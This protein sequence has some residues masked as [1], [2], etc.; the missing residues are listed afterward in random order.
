MAVI[1]IDG[2]AIFRSASLFLILLG[3]AVFARFMKVAVQHDVHIDGIP[4]AILIAAVILGPAE[5][6]VI[7]ILMVLIGEL[8]YPLV[9]YIENIQKKAPNNEAPSMGHRL[10]LW[11][12]EPMVQSDT[13]NEIERDVSKA[14]WS[15]V[16]RPVKLKI[17]EDVAQVSCYALIAGLFFRYVVD[18]FGINYLDPSFY[19]VF[20]AAFVLMLAVN[21]GYYEIVVDTWIERYPFGSGFK[22]IAFLIPAEIVTVSL[23]MGVLYG[24]Y[25]FGSRTSAMLLMA[26]G[27]SA[28]LF[29]YWRAQNSKVK[30]EREA[31][32]RLT[33]RVQALH[34]RDNR[35]GTHCAAIALYVYE[36]ACAAGLSTK[37]RFRGYRA[38]LVHDVGK[39]SWPGPLLD[40]T[41]GRDEITEVDRLYIKDHP[42]AGADR[43]LGAGF[44]HVAQIIRCH[45]EN[46]DGTGYPRGFQG[47][48]IPELAKI[49]RVADTYDVI[50]ARDTYQSRRSREEAI[51]ELR[52]K[53]ELFEQ[54]YV[55]ALVEA[56]EKD[57]E[58]NYRHEDRR[59]YEEA[60]DFYTA[61][62]PRKK[63]PPKDGQRVKFPHGAAEPTGRESVV[64][65]SSD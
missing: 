2:A 52:S 13:G 16:E 33:S 65:G 7:G 11:L 26:A 54:I 25:A 50:T 44:K 46:L 60:I 3:L 53:P 34:A 8:Y 63:R 32:N 36:I 62:L 6:A 61:G 14:G 42:N 47:H 39:T 17:L 23:G 9:S 29:Y 24:Y 20:L 28:V 55:E 41:K 56:L 38:G 4:L 21:F 18:A 51:A 48:E 59:T 37:Q 19:L 10:L 22:I 45:H 57:P 43:I 31:F 1:I 40:G 12:F 27:L 64:K 5:A 49:I 35:T 15:S 58:L 30:I